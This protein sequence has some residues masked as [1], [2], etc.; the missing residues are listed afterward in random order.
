MTADAPSLFDAPPDTG[1]HRRS[2][3]AT[4]VAAAASVDVPARQAEVLDALE[5]LGG[6]ATVSEVVDCL[7]W[8]G[9]HVE[10]GPTSRRITDL[11][12]AGWV[13]PTSE[14]RPGRTGRPQT[15]WSRVR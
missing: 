6:K 9:V 12:A 13:E 10:H 2:D 3:P 11:V 7:A 15:V 14:I 4:S 5:T 8:R 1:T